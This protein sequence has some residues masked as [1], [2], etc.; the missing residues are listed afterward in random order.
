M[1]LWGRYHIRQVFELLPFRLGLAVVHNRAEFGLE[2]FEHRGVIEEVERQYRKDMR[3][4]DGPSGNNNLGLVQQVLCRFLL[5]AQVRV[6]KDIIEDRR[7]PHWFVAF[8][9]VGFHFEELVVNLLSFLVSII[10]RT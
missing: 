7:L 10:K 3:R 9:E 4:R 6:C 5:R 1:R 2:F 8:G